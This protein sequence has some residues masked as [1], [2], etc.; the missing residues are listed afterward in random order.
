MKTCPFCGG[1]A[2]MDSGLVNGRKDDDLDA[3]QFWVR[4]GMGRTRRRLGQVRSGRY[5][6]LGDESGMNKADLLEEWRNVCSQ[7]EHI[8]AL[9]DHG[10]DWESLCVGWCLAKG[11]TAEQAYVFYSQMIPFLF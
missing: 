6:L 4:W 1:Q 2:I 8:E 5:S 7:S 9:S 11:L 3:R 10:N